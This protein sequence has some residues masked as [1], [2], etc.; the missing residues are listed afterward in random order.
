MTRRSASGHDVHGTALTFGDLGWIGQ[1][2]LPFDVPEWL[3]SCFEV[4][5][6]YETI[7]AQLLAAAFVIGSYY[8]AEYMKV[9]RPLKRSE[10]PAVRAAVVPVEEPA[11]TARGRGGFEPAL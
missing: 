4:Y 7:G 5:G 11:P 6:Y 3:G 9:T 2:P 8:L 1:T 10:Q